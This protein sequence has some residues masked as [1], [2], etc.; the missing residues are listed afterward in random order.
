M[1]NGLVW[2]AGMVAGISKYVQTLVSVGPYRLK[3]LGSGRRSFSIR[4]CLM[5]KT[6]PAN[7]TNRRSGN[8]YWS[9]FPYCAKKLKIEGVEYQTLI[10]LLAISGARRMGSLPTSSATSTNVAPCFIETYISRIERSK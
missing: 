6:S 9:N 1:G 4:R 8:S 2:A 3:Y 7:N 5:G 10:F